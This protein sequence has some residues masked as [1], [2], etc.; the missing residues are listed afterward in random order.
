MIR[1]TVELIPP[2]VGTPEVLGVAEIWNT[3][4]GSPTQGSYK[5]VF[6]GKRG[7]YLRTVAVTGFPRKRRLAWDLLLRCLL[8][9]FGDRN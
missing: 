4:K 8:E 3:L 1:V 7:H 9:A 6:L 2:G 5:G